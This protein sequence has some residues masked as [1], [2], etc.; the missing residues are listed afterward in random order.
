MTFPRR[1]RARLRVLAALTRARVR[2]RRRV[3][4]ASLSRTSELLAAVALCGALAT[5]E[6]CERRAIGSASITRGEG[7]AA[8]R[9]SAVCF[10]VVCVVQAAAAY[11]TVT[12]VRQRGLKDGVPSDPLGDAATVMWRQHGAYLCAVAVTVVG[13]SVRVAALLRLTI[14]P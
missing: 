14:S 7:A 11:A 8:R 5:E 12:I 13:V 2:Q 10:A 9:A 1:V 3:K 6:L 4:L